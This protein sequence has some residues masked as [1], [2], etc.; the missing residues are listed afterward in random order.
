M[1]DSPEPMRSSEENKPTVSFYNLK[2]APEDIKVGD[3]VSVIVTGKVTETSSS[4]GYD[5]KKEI[6][7]TLSVERDSCKVMKGKSDMADMDMDEYAKERA[8]K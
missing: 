7:H 4:R 1:K 6:N 3:T 5:N 2:N 8:K